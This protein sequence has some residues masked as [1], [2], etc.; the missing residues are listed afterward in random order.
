MLTAQTAPAPVGDSSYTLFS[1]EYNSQ[2]ELTTITNAASDVTVNEYSSAGQV[3]Q[4]TGS[5][6]EWLS[7]IH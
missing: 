2:D 6:T 7:R 3:V 4:T 5:L 1:Y